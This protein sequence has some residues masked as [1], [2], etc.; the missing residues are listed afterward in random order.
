ML[1]NLTAPYDY[2]CVM[3]LKMGQRTHADTD[4]PDKVRLKTQRAKD[5][6]SASLGFRV[7]GMQVNFVHH[8]QYFFS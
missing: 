4:D 5:T 2:P 1:E 3:D 7:C 8:L 6:T